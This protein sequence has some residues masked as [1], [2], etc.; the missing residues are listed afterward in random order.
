MALVSGTAWLVPDDADAVALR[1]GDVAVLRG[2]DGY[3]VADDPATPPQVVIHPGQRCT[4]LHGEPLTESMAL[5]VRTW[6][7]GPHGSTV[8]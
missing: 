2:P 7:T 1:L 4:T 6:G 5:G 3:L 8:G